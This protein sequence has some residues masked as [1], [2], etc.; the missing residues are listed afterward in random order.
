[1]QLKNTLFFF[2]LIFISFFSF[3]FA[4][5][6]HE[7]FRKEAEAIKKS[8]KNV[9][10]DV[11]RIDLKNMLGR[12]YVQMKD[13]DQ[14]MQIALENKLLAE[15]IKYGK[16]KTAAQVCIG[17]IYRCQDNFKKSNS[18]FDEALTL[19]KTHQDLFSEALIYDQLGHLFWSKKDTLKAIS[20]HEKALQ[21]RKQL[22]NYIHI[23][24]SYSNIAQIYNAQGKTKEALQYFQNGLKYFQKTNRYEK[25]A[26]GAGNVGMMQNWLGNRKEAL[27]YFIIAN[28]NYEKIG[29]NEGYVWMSNSIA[30]IYNTIFDFENAFKYIEKIRK[31]HA[32]TKSINGF[33]DAHIL[34]GN[35]HFNMKNFEKSSIQYK[36]ANE[37]YKTINDSIGIMNSLISMGTVNFELKNYQQAFQNTH[38]SLTFA[39]LLNQYRI[40]AQCNLMLGDIYK[41]TG[42]SK[43]ARESLRAA[44]NYYKES[45]SIN[46]LSAVYKS[47]AKLDSIDGDYMSA[48]ENYKKFIHY[49]QIYK[50]S[51]TD[52]EKIAMRYKFEK[53]QALDALELKNKKTE[54]NAAIFGLILTTFLIVVLVYFFRLRNKK[55]KIEKEKI[56]LQK[57]DIERIK[58][59]ELFKSRFL[60]NITH[61]FRTPLTLIKGHLE[62]LKENG[63]GEDQFRFDE[64]D[65]NGSRLL[66]LINQ[67]LDLS[68]MESG[69][70][71]LNYRS[72]NIINETIALSQSFQSLAD[73]NQVE[74]IINKDLADVELA[75]SFNYSQEALASII[76]NLLSNSFKFTPAGGVITVDILIDSPAIFRIQVSDTGKGIPAASLPKIFDRFYQVDQT[77][78]RSYEG[79]GIGLALVKELALIHG[80]DVSVESIDGKGCVFTVVLKSSSDAEAIEKVEI[81]KTKI[82]SEVSYPTDEE[83]F[84]VKDSDLPLILVV[85]DHQELRRFIIDNM[86]A[87]YVFAEA[88]NGQEGIQKA[89]ELMPDLI[90]SDVM[91]PDID[92]LEMCQHLKANKITSHI[93]IM[94]LTAKADDADKIMGLEMGANDYLTKPFSLAEIKLRVKNILN[95][96]QLLREKL[97]GSVI[98]KTTKI[99]GLNKSDA[100]FIEKI[101]E[102]IRKNL[103]NS[104]LDVPLL[105][106]LMFLSVSQFGRKL[107]N[108]T[109]KSPA[110]YIR[111]YK[112][113]EAVQFLIDG[114]SVAETGYEIGF[115]DTV[116]FSKVFKKHFGY[117]PSEVNK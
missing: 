42:E 35:I 111:N 5:Q 68:K 21:L 78:Q 44:Y 72:G 15:K 106:D 86:G 79:S 16:G 30:N 110:E 74:L 105:A 75:K 51:D 52:T 113:Q 117:P 37:I 55:I 66:Q 10:T 12:V 114:K 60:T 98:L 9:K 84:A 24:E 3:S 2:H 43:K 80:G 7:A 104:Q 109:G 40:I 22:D 116:Y 39:S 19:A 47:L 77:D 67:L 61:E 90:I 25:I 36:K 63:R 100:A 76:A 82:I 34:E 89:E 53:Q 28:D 62:V 14:A 11:E 69:E 64:M 96:R 13:Y 95:L 6:D 92:G 59:T 26:W 65:N 81:Q 93:P 46:G 23:G 33:A 88:V 17:E 83:D 91:M 48:F 56:D 57:L 101:Q 45:E 97:E 32:M 27:K 107:K 8:I 58:E 41:A 115:A 4:Q 112:L 29:N 85:E 102:I 71:K 18:S 54:R 87:E 103:S 49:S 70:Y 73:Q 94:L 1:M 31:N 108:M 99:D 38:L 50:V 20:N